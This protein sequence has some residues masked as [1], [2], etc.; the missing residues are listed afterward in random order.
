MRLYCVT[1]SSIVAIVAFQ[2]ECKNDCPD[3]DYGIELDLNPWVEL[4]GCQ[5]K[6]PAG[7]LQLSVIEV[8]WSSDV[9]LV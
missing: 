9:G 8:L 5:G 7:C 4:V 2:S 6:V 3:R 1:S